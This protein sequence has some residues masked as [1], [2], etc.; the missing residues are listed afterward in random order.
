MSISVWRREGEALNT[1]NTSPTVQHGASSMYAVGLFC[2]QWICCSKETKW[3][4]E[5]GGL[6][7]NSSGKHKIISRRWALVCSWVFQQNT[8]KVKI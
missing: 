8:C 4:N 3:N 1:K 6:S 2:C 7:P 5:E